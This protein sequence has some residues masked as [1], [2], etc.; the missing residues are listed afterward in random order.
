MSYSGVYDVTLALR[1]LLHSRLVRVIPTAIVTL[2]P[3][4][5]ELPDAPG[6]NLYLYRVSE[7]PATRNRPWPGDRSNPG[8]PQPALGLELSYLLTPLGK[9]PEDTKFDNGDEAHRMLGAAMLALDQY[10]VLNDVH[11][12]P[13]GGVADSGFDA[14]RALSQALLDSFEQIKITLLP[15]NIEEISKIWAAI[16]KPYRLSVAYEVSLLELTPDVPPPV[17]GG[18]VTL[19]D[20]GVV[21]MQ[22]PSISALVPSSGPVA[23]NDGTVANTL[24]IEGLGLTAPGT[25]TTV[26]IG[27]QV[28]D[29]DM[30][31]ATAQKLVATLPRQLDAGP[32]VDV[33]VSAGGQFSG[34][35]T[36]IVH[37]WLA[38]I[39]PVRVPLDTAA[40]ATLE[41]FGEGFTATP[42]FVRF[43]P[44]SGAATTALPLAGGTDKH[45][46]VQ[47]PA[48]LANGLYEVVLVLND[49]PH[50]ATN[51]RQLEIAPLLQP[52]IVLSTTVVAGKT[53][54]VATISG[55]RLNGAAVTLAIDGVSYEAGANATANQL[56]YTF[57]RL[58]AAGKHALAVSVDGHASNAVTF[59]V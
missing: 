33:R 46:S 37:P 2:L 47:I 26:R 43:A 49:G 59:G 24:T 3:P 1:M 22:P 51:V 16:N 14:D 21:T 9:K 13:L 32:F 25:T 50:S 18:I 19:T 40:P 34:P 8:T 38:R 41:L 27:G 55:Q 58:L 23:A 54:S 42:Q 45:A 29:V 36:F 56:V 28:A 12:P 31:T 53:V 11:V 15:T 5:D 20:V 7:S 44:A 17:G 39:A 6:V 4:G 57:G 35:A 52:P 10:P 48:A 30:N